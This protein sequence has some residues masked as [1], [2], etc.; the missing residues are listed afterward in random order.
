[1]KTMMVYSTKTGHTKKVA[2][3]IA[4]PLGITAHSLKEDLTIEN[5]DLLFIGS[6]IYA[7]KIS[8]EL[9]S[10]VNTLEKEN[11]KKFAPFVSNVTGTKPLPK[12]RE[13]L[14]KKGIEV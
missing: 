4:K 2:D 14:Q 13:I 12:V 7:G 1:M 11:V 9:E 5:V 6:G 10:F 3:A 8:S